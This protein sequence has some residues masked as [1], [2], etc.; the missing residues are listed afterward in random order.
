MSVDISFDKDHA[1]LGH[2]K[3][4]GPQRIVTGS[5]EFDNDYDSGGEEMDLSNYMRRTTGVFIASNSGYVFEYDYDEE[6]VKVYQAD[7]SAG[8]LTEVSGST[9][10]SALDD[11]KFMAW[12]F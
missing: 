11:V 3:V 6:K 5:I 8:A 9:D 4:I 2:V 10:L 1:M 12:G 7:G